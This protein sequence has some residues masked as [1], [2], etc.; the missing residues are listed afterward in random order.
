M[1]AL[2]TFFG[3]SRDGSPEVTKGKRRLITY[4][5]FITFCLIVA[6]LADQEWVSG[7]LEFTVGATRDGTP[8]SDMDCLAAPCLAGL[9]TS[10]MLGATVQVSFQLGLSTVGQNTAYNMPFTGEAV[11]RDCQLPTLPF[12]RY[13]NAAMVSNST[14]R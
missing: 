12:L 6:A 4:S 5:S 2:A 1:S 3:L 9:D 13:I 14:Q 8:L 7:G 10:R 11:E